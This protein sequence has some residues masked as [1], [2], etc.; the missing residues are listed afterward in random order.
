MKGLQIRALKKGPSK[1]T[2]KAAK[3]DEKGTGQTRYKAR[4]S[5]IDRTVGK[6]RQGQRQYNRQNSWER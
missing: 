1:R 5:T 6:G 4:D 2:A 3:Q